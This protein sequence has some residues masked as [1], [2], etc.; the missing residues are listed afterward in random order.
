[1]GA[2]DSED[3]GLAGMLA[4]FARTGDPTPPPAPESGG[5]SRRALE[6]RVAALEACVAAQQTSIENLMAAVRQVVDRG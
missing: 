3:G 1:M 2:E 4:A 5:E 6:A